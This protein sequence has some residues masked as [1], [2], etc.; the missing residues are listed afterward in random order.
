[1]PGYLLTA[2]STVQCSHGGQAQATMPSPRVRAAGGPLVT[3]SAPHSVAGCPFNVAGGPVP[4]V[5]AQWTVGATRVRSLGAPVL[6]QDSQAVC[7]PNG[8]PV[9]VV[10]TQT[11]VKGT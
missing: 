4:C 8:T 6:L 7:A 3:M 11:R 10:A 2:A 9:T 5:V 1:M